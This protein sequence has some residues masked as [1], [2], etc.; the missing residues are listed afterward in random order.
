MEMLLVEDDQDD[1]EAVVRLVAKSGLDVQVTTA[2]S[3]EQAAE[4]LSGRPKASRTGGRQAPDVVLLDL[5]LPATSGMEFLRWLKT[6]DEL[7]E[8]PVVI[9]SA[10]AIRSQIR[11]L[12]D[13]GVRAY[14]T[15][16]LDV[17][18]LLALLEEILRAGGP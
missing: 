18:Q 1:I 8:I 16:P 3:G 10:D 9:L 15:K 2:T 11:R 12:V 13:A 14:L 7:R 6:E 4:Q 5:N 17:R